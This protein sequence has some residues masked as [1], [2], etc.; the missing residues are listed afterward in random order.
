[1]ISTE[2][3]IPHSL[4]FQEMEE[5][6][7]SDEL[8]QLKANLQLLQQAQVNQSLEQQQ[9][10]VTLSNIEKMLAKIATRG[11][12]ET[13]DSDPTPPLEEERRT[14]ETSFSSSRPGKYTKKL[15]DPSPLS[16]GIDPTFEGWMI[17]IRGKLRGN[18]DHFPTEE[19]RMF[20]IFNRTTGDA[21][22]HL[23]P[24]YD[25]DSLMRF[26]SSEEMIRH[27]TPIYVNPNKVRDARYDYNRLVMRTGQSFS[28]FQTNFLH[29]AGEA[30]IP[31]TSFR[32]DLYDK[33]TTKLQDRL[34][35]VLDDLES[36]EKLSTRC[37]SLDT[38]L[39]RIS[40]RID[41]QK[42][43]QKEVTRPEPTGKDSARGLVP[44]PRTST[45]NFGRAISSGPENLRSG[46]TPPGTT[47]YNC[48]QPGHIS[49]DCPQP[50]KSTDLKE[51][52]ET[53]EDLDNLESENEEA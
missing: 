24:R 30:Q 19:D 15:P 25:E 38:K 11:E 5:D 12:P 21:Q 40:G 27:L 16:D 23:L 43:F 18:S 2:P 36:Y 9:A 10:K 52:E 26:T 7:N 33:L 44:F 29:L 28:D 47:C 14:R 48:G 37:L 4:E 45:P 41:R 1:V 42:H 22:K 31:I 32:L 35:A 39:R 51:I 34:A 6:N 8:A 3:S 13:S 17:Q 50:K 46:S 20:Y 49:R 53:E